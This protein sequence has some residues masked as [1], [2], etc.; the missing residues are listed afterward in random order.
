M[1]TS[2][3]NK[4]QIMYISN[5]I[6]VQLLLT[7]FGTNVKIYYHIIKWSKYDFC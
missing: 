6:N 5:L 1:Y 2:L 3:Y 4:T 7:Y